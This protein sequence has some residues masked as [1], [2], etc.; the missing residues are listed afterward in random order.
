MLILKTIFTVLTII[1]LLLTQSVFSQKKDFEAKDGGLGISA[2][3]YLFF[4]YNADSA[5]FNEAGYQAGDMQ[6]Y[7]ADLSVLY[8]FDEC[9][10]V[11]GGFG[12]EYMNKPVFRYYLPY[13]GVK[14]YLTEDK[15][16]SYARANIG[17]NFGNDGEAGTALRAGI[18]FRT[19]LTKNISGLIEV[20]W[21]YQGIN[22]TINSERIS[23][24][25]NFKAIGF[26]LGLELF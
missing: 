22:K 16:T 1:T 4:P 8:F 5:G 19:P 23:G 17:V 24:Y 25:Y 13:L 26:S 14:L 9:F 10:A 3:T 7:G 18:G 11:Q 2:Q 12:Y 20:L 15:L 21:S 6:I